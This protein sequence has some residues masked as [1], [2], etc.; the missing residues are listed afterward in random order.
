M[1]PN[2]YGGAGGGGGSDYINTG[3][4]GYL[5]TVTQTGGG[6]ANGGANGGK[7]GGNGSILIQFS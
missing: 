4:S 7:P 6:A 5:T 3:I 2:P 1:S